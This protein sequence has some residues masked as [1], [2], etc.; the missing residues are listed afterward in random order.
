[1]GVAQDVARSAWDAYFAGDIDAVVDQMA[2]DVEIHMSNYQ[3]WPE[4]AVYYGQSGFRRFIEGWLAGW[5]RYEAGLDELIEVSP[6]CILTWSWQRA[7]GAGSHV[8]VEMHLAGIA[9]VRG[10]RIARLELWSDREAA[11]AEALRR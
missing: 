11:R 3:G 5:E 10:D 7:Y 4:D 1:M 8:P 9:T 6:G 2:S